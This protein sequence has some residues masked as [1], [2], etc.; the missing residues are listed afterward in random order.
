[1]VDFIFIS[2]GFLMAII[3]GYF[4][5]DQFKAWVISSLR[6][7]KDS[8]EKMNEELFTPTA[9]NTNV[10]SIWIGDT[11]SKIKD[12][13]GTTYKFVE[14]V[15]KKTNKKGLPKKKITKKTKKASKK[16]VTKKPTK[17][18]VSKK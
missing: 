5:V 17:K 13:Y 11:V 18:K 9:I 7:K 1:M 8:E 3:C 2:L 4:A 12:D 14:V 15:E 6:R 16:K 10:E